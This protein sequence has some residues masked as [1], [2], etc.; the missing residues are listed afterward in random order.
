MSFLSCRIYFGPFIRKLSIQFILH[1]HKS[2][3]HQRIARNTCRW[4][5][6]ISNLF[7]VIFF[8]VKVSMIM[9]SGNLDFCISAQKH[10]I[11]N[12]GG[13]LR[14]NNVYN[15]A[16]VSAEGTIVNITFSVS[17]CP[18]ELLWSSISLWKINFILHSWQIHIAFRSSGCIFWSHQRWIV[19]LLYL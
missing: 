7:R 2:S 3:V 4:D 11:S 19:K 15:H 18:V 9:S 12:Q 13:T 16:N 1:N 17:L 6:I 5:Y 10:V 8:T 14:R